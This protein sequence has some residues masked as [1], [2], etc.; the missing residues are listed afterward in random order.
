MT[1]A[2]FFQSIVNP[3][4]SVLVRTSGLPVTR[5][6]DSR[7]RLL[8]VAIAGQESGWDARRQEPGPARGWWQFE[9]GGINGV[10]NHPTSGPVLAKLCAEL[11][12]P[13]EP[14]VLYEATAWHDHLATG[15]ARLLLWTDQRTLP[16]I[17][18]ADGAWS[19]YERNWR[20]GKPR[21]Q[22][23]RQNYAQAKTAIGSVVA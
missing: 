16:A 7:A 5:V 14:D 8:L 2:A 12:I 3:G 21:P 17:D 1:P 6:A 19:Y 4:L 13:Y 23:W 18:D 22:D 11:V 15:L 10:M 20:P 9:A